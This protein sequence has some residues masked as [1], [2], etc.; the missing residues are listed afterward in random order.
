M[1]TET[2]P[3]AAGLGLT[4]A[5]VK[6]GVLVL[7]GVAYL[8]I[9]SSGFVLDDGWTFVSNGFLRYPGHLPVLLEGRGAELAIPDPFR[10]LLVAFDAL[11]YHWLGLDAR[12]HHLLSLVL[13]L[14]VCLTLDRLLAR[15]EAPD[16]VRHVSM[17]TF[18]L[19]GIHAEAISVISYREDLLAALLGIAAITLATA[20]ARHARRERA[21]RL[22]LAALCMFAAMGA[23]LSAAPLPAAAWLLWSWPRWRALPPMRQR[24]VGVL[25]LTLGVLLGLA[26]R[27]KLTGQLLPYTAD[28]PRTSWWLS[29]GASAPGAAALFSL[30]ALSRTLLP[31]GLAPEYSP[32]IPAAGTLTYVVALTVVSGC[33][34]GA[35]LWRWRQPRAILPVIVLGWAALWLPTS[36]LIPLPNPEADRYAYL[37]SFMVCVGLGALASAV[38]ARAN[39]LL[40]R[41]GGGGDRCL[42]DRPRLA[43]THRQPVLLQ[44]LHTLGDLDAAGPRVRAGARHARY[45]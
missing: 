41:R 6:L 23:K 3:V 37:P 42:S 1:S 45:R 30:R 2:P 28:D 43:R 8:P 35:A 15:L 33:L 44:Q 4:P 40:P 13:H 11:T 19:L 10:P 7:I 21:A 16:V 27:W 17:A 39:G 36:N 34:V 31:V 12:M 14:G 29:Q 38:L 9:L 5:A 18:G 22:A 26:L 24:V 32:A 25:A 20:D